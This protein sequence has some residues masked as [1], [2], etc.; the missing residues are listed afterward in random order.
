MSSSIL[1]LGLGNILLQDEGLGVAALDRL[2]TAYRLPPEVRAVDGGT[3]GL[4]LLP[5]LENVDAL[6]IVDAVK[7]GQP[8]GTLVRLE[9]QAIPAGLAVKMSMHQ[10]GLGELLAVSSLQG[11][12]PSRIVLWG[13]EPASF[14]WGVEL[15]P[16]VAEKLD[17]LVKA[18]AE[19]LQDWGVVVEPAFS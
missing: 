7:T 17:A 12:L 3:L 13:M 9:G 18:V 2:T 1:I 14:E 5:L 6:L 8:P 19:E 16:V 15:S 4:D 10:F 11:I